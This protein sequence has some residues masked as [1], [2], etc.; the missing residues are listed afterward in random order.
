M[1]TPTLQDIANNILADLESE[2]GTSIPIFAKSVWRI[3]S[4]ILAGV[5]II[6]YKYSGD[7]YKQRFVQTAN[8]TYLEILGELVGIVRTPSQAWSGQA[9]A[10]A[11]GSGTIPAGT[12]LRNVATGVVYRLSIPATIASTTTMTLLA[13]T[14]GDVSDI[15]IG[16]EL[17][18]VSP[19]GGVSQTAI[20]LAITTQGAD[21]ENLEVYR[22]RVLDRYRKTPQGGALADYEQWTEEGPNVINAYPYSGTMPVHVD[23]YVEVDNQTDGIPTTPQLTNI[24]DNYIAVDPDIGLA[25]R[26]PITD[27]VT[28]FQIERIEFD[29]EIITL[30]PDTATIRDEIESALETYFL[31]KA[32]YIQ[33]LTIT[34][35]DNITNSEVTS[36]IQEIV[37]NN[38]ATILNVI[39]REG[40][41]LVDVRGLGRGEKSKLGTVTYS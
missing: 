15:N 37:S 5:F 33:G 34:K 23:I 29:V 14:S 10:I 18:F 38:E 40:G 2:F 26:K 3:F 7:Q 12:Q 13:L 39:T 30:D 9:Q 28:M 1:T 21:K 22:Q 6:L 25:T 31:R 24:Y 36:V 20:V 35:D 41:T 8:E 27:I 11:T 16:D 17:K 19:I 32:P 4:Y